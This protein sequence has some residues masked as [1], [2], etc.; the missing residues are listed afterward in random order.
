MIIYMFSCIHHLEELG[1][2]GFM[3]GL[4]EETEMMH[5]ILCEMI[6]CML[7]VSFF[8]CMCCVCVVY[9]YVCVCVLCV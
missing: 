1:K 7:S 8:V 3:L 9:V 4:L 6:M 5:P 2:D